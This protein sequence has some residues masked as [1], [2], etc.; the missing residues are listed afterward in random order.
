MA[1]L[2]DP[3]SAQSQKG[4]ILGSLTN[5]RGG[6]NIKSTHFK[7]DRYNPN[8]WVD[9]FDMFE[10]VKAKI[11][12]MAPED[13]CTTWEGKAMI[14]RWFEDIYSMANALGLCF[15]PFGA[16][17]A[18]G[19]TYISKL[20]SA[21]TGRDATP[22]DIIK[23]GERIFTIFKAYTVRDGLTRKDDTWPDRF[24]TEPLPEGPGKGA[25]V[26]KNTIEQVL[27]EYYG[28]R[29]WDKESGLPTEEKL[30]ELGLHDLADDLIG[31]LD[32][33]SQ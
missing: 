11:Y 14:C 25:V 23:L 7:A 20:L 19:P 10:D 27:D 32:Y 17:L 9:K 2:P 15:T 22:A 29:G 3:R 30:I 18:L 6:D 24:F 12:G 4:W 16:Y 1:M 13:F 5:P 8:W 21:C 28:L 31:R 33:T 26:S